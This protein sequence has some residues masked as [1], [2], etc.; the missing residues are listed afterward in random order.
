MSCCHGHH[1]RLFMADADA[2]LIVVCRVV[3]DLSHCHLDSVFRMIGTVQTN[4]YLK[5][6][7]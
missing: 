7:K 3:L 6:V 2:F 1:V 4:R 5:C